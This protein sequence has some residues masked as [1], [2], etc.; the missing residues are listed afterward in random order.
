[1]KKLMITASV[2]VVA[3]GLQAASLKWGFTG[4]G[5]SK[6]ASGNWL[7]D[8]V[9]PVA[10]LYLGTVSASDSAF[11]FGDATKLITA[12]GLSSDYTLGS[13]S[14]AV[15]LSDTLLA[16]DAAGQAYTLIILEDNGKSIDNYEG[17]YIL[18]K[19]VSGHGSNPMDESDTWA[20]F[21]NIDTYAASD[22]SKMTASV[23]E[24]T[25]GLL[26]LIG[27][28]GLALKRKRA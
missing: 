7:G 20:T 14:V 22:W 5:N 24:P 8:V 3:C 13:T 11:S 16:S 17:N 18:A 12:T 21:I 26:L 27:M 10:Y 28:A 23:P 19:G 15:A 2:M 6:D 9:T 4:T 25:S 1:M